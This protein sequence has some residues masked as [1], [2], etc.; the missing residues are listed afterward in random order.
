MFT[1]WTA[2]ALSVGVLVWNARRDYRPFWTDNSSDFTSQIGLRFRRVEFRRI[3]YICCICS[4][5]LVNHCS[6][7]IFTNSFACCKPWLAWNTKRSWD[8]MNLKISQIKQLGRR[9]KP[10]RILHDQVTGEN[11]IRKISRYK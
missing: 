1:V 5:G 3:D 8:Y 9:L 10:C 2:K 4:Q 11:S 6:V 7:L